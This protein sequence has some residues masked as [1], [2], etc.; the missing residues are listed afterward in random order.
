MGEKIIDA[1]PLREGEFFIYATHPSK[2]LLGFEFQPTL[3]GVA[4]I[5][6]ISIQTPLTYL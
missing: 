6:R 1:T 4:S 3:E 5:Y 2:H